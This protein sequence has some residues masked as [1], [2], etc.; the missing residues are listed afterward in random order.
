MTINLVLIFNV[1]HLSV[2]NYIFSWQS[3][4]WGNCLWSWGYLGSVNA[5]ISSCTE[6]IK[7]WRNATSTLRLTFINILFLKF[8]N[9]ILGILVTIAD[10]NKNDLFRSGVANPGPRA[11]FGPQGL[12]KSPVKAFRLLKTEKLSYILAFN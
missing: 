2:I 1:S 7:T 10:F 4:F 12:C 9:C 8:C 5:F 3:L 6:T 11:I